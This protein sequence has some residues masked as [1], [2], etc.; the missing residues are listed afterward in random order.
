MTRSNSTPK[1]SVV[2]PVYNV[3][4]YLNYCV[5]SLL[6]QEYSNLEIILVDD[7][8]TDRSP[9]I[10]DSFLELDERV[11]VIH[12]ANGGLSDAR[13]V[14]LEAS[15]GE[16]VSFVDSDDWVEPGFISTLL[17]AMLEHGKDIAVC[18]RYDRHG[19]LSKANFVASELMVL[20]KE[21]A[22]R[23]Y[24]LGCIIDVAAWDKLYSA[25][26]IREYAFP[27]GKISED[28]FIMHHVFEAS[29]GCVHVSVPLYNYRHRDNSI[30]TSRFSKKNMEV[31]GA[32]LETWEFI[33]GKYPSLREEL[34]AYCLRRLSGILAGAQMSDPV[35]PDYVS[36]LKSYFR[37]KTFGDY[38][39]SKYLSVVQKGVI[40][41]QLAGLY[42]FVRRVVSTFRGH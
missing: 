14:G 34:S 3:E 15:T 29:N 17:Y 13:N 33:D 5:D 41:L 21:E 30:T 4:D 19:D 16:Y 9:A 27:L 24:L 18:G 39:S 20:S 10:C 38:R 1:V 26:L 11:R 40:A 8:S 28:M 23:Q 35:K 31:C 32:L 36:T 2:V 7:G 42:P 6:S 25:E 22:L 12:K 37:Q